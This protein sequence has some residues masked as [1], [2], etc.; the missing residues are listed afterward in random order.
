[1]SET[2]T[3]SLASTPARR[4]RLEVRRLG[5][6]SMVKT[7]FLIGGASGFVAGVLQWLFLQSLFSYSY[8]ATMQGDFGS[9]AG[10]P[11][12]MEIFGALAWILPLIGGAGGAATGVVMGV[13]ITL[14]YNLGARIWG[15]VELE[16]RAVE[17]GTQIAALP[18]APRGESTPLPITGTTPPPSSPP[19]A[20]A[21]AARPPSSL[22]FE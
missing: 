7:L 19:P 3:Q 14:F 20:D 15:G 5:M 17:S 2:I 1:M 13:V 22:S 10:M 4:D 16:L 6:L 12:L 8:S 9:M 18:V 21:P 11:N